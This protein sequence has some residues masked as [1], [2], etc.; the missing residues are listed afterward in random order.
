MRP[1]RCRKAACRR[2]RLALRI[3]LNHLRRLGKKDLS[4]RLV[5]ELYGKAAT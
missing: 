1:V 5:V 2:R 3:A 4:A